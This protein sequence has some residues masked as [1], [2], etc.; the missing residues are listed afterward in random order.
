MEAA[1]HRPQARSVRPKATQ[2]IGPNP[3]PTDDTLTAY[4]DLCS[5]VHSQEARHSQSYLTNAP[6]YAPG[7][8]IQ[9]LAELQATGTG[10]RVAGGGWRVAGGGWCMVAEIMTSVDIIV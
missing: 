4:L 3:V 5:Q 2:A 7:C 1:S 9:R 10:R 8:S 6:M